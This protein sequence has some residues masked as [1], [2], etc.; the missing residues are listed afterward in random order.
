VLNE[1]LLWLP[2]LLLVVVT[3]ALLAFIARPCGRLRWLIAAIV[4]GTP[5]LFPSDGQFTNGHL[6]VLSTFITSFAIVT[7]VRL[8]DFDQIIQRTQL[9]R[10]RVYAWL[11]LPLVNLS[12][13]SLAASQRWAS[14][15]RYLTK[16]G[17]KRLA[18]EV[19]ALVA[20][21]C[22]PLPW[23][24]K[25]ALLVFYF[26]LNTTAFHD[27]VAGLCVVAGLGIDELFDAPLLSRSP[28]DFW[29]TR[30][31]KFINRFALKY[32]ALKVR[33]RLS[34]FL[35]LFVVFLCSGLFHEYFAWGV[36]GWT[37]APGGMLAF[38]SI[39]AVAVWLGTRLPWKA[40]P[41]LTQPLTF[42]WM[43][44]SAPLFFIEVSPAFLAFGYPQEWL[45]FEAIHFWGSIR[46]FP[47][48]ALNG[49][50]L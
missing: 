38:F 5:A 14:A 10:W 37:R 28:R 45:P 48:E 19:L 18:W 11:S 4:L 24:C 41:W 40:S 2:A 15:L 17:A 39:Q 26:V 12:P 1:A 42:V 20:A 16:A 32:V 47:T 30:W 34:P 8:A 13:P 49:L 44:I 23:A 21:Q 46:Q 25:S 6:R 27:L 50:C 43:L 22:E 35:T 7:A 33:H 3:N 36:G 9:S 29:S 31:N